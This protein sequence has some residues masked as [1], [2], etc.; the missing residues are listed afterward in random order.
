MNIFCRRTLLPLL[1]VATTTSVTAQETLEEMVVIS[2]RVEMPLRHLGTAVSTLDIE[3]IQLS[4][5]TSLNDVLRTQT[6]VAVSNNGGAGKPGTLRIR[7]EEGFRTLVLMDGLD[8]SD[9]T[10]T[11]VGPRME[12]LLSSGVQRVELLRGP[13]GMM[14]GAD[15]GGVVKISSFDTREGFAGDL[16]A[17]GGRYGTSQVAA[18]LGGGNGTLDG[19]LSLSDFQT[20]GFN[21]RDTDTELRDNDGYDNQTIHARL[22]WNIGDQFRVE[23]VARDVSSDNQY[24]GCF[25][26]DPFAPSDDCSNSFDQQSWRLGLLHTGEQFSNQLNYNGNETKNQDYTEGG[27]TFGSKGD[28]ERLS[29]LG[30]YSRSD[31]LRLVYGVDLKT[32]SLDD[33]TFDRERDQDGYYLEYQGGF[34]ETWFV[35]AG[36]RYDDNEDFGEHTSYRLSGAYLLD[37]GDSDL[38]LRAAYGTGFR[39]PSLYEVTYNGVWGFPPASNVE[40]TEETSQGY[41]LGVVWY[42]ENG[43]QLEATWFDQ[44]VNDEIYFDLATFSGYLQGDGETRSRGV[45]LV[46]D[47]PLGESLFLSAN[48]TYNKTDS[49]G[50]GTRA[51]RPKHL[52]NAGLKWL[53]L[54]DRLVLNLAVRGS[55]DAVDTDGSELDDYTVLN[56]SATMEVLD[57][58]KLFGRIENLTDEDY[59]EV[60]TYNTSSAAAYAGVRYSF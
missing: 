36:L 19:S 17:E 30:S 51:R 2:S 40:L 58:L 53:A 55:Y 33:G 15:A 37:T 10:G 5:F 44:R 48:Y 18:S 35:T 32:E 60:P 22:G 49:S 43:L 54:A 45:E 26:S 50:G 52:T 20:D 42:R 41:D 7:G 46:G 56:F 25:T 24:D 59:Q 14:Y 3:D 11:Q 31:S 27:P 16:S 4:G 47:V 23:A 8:I 38:K 57:G 9:T 34:S 6:G 13:Q 21:A 29:Y 12:H 39:A 1:L 28:L